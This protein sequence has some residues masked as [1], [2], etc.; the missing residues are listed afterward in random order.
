[1]VTL[2]AIV[3]NW[4][5]QSLAVPTVLFRKEALNWFEAARPMEPEARRAADRHALAISEATSS[6]LELV[7]SVEN[8]WHTLTD[9]EKEEITSLAYTII[10][11]QPNIFDKIRAARL[12]ARTD[13]ND[14]RALGEAVFEFIHQVLKRVEEADEELQA[15]IDEALGALGSGGT[16]VTADTVVEHLRSLQ[17]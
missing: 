16:R 14:F 15:V 11:Y 9:K 5:M 2:Y 4:P 1:M 3:P 13:F 6:L 17:D 10:D 12:L 8:N 7:E